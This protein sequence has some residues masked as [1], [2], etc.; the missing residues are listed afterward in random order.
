ML[1]RENKEITKGK[2]PTVESVTRVV[3]KILATEYMKDIFCY[4]VVEKNG[5]ISL[6]YSH[7]Q[8]KLECIRREYLGKTVL[9]TDRKDFTN[10]QIITAYRSAWH[11]EAAFKQMKNPEHLSV[12][13]IFHWTDEKI[14]VHIF[15]CVLA[16]RLCSLL[17][18][19]LSQKGISITINQLMNEM[20]HIKRIHT[21]F[22]D[23]N[24][25]EKVESFTLGNE[26]ARQIE[27]LYRLKE[28]YS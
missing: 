1:R 3:E 6:T 22:G 12:R 11:I 16:Y 5:N 18:K 13:P 26:L 8:L 10:E 28:K 25:P 19:E 24:K 21:F 4:Q 17:I 9:F 23:I 14:R 2:K 15:I 20:A 27:Q 7:S